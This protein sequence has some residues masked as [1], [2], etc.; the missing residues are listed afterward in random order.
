[1]TL[2]QHVT[3]RQ[4]QLN[5]TFVKSGC[6]STAGRLSKPDVSGTMLN[7]DIVNAMSSHRKLQHFLGAWR[8]V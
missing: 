1:M 7:P 3:S 6:Y 4:Q 8:F 2:M 5:H